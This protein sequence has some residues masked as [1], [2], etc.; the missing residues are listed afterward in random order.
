M[1]RRIIVLAM[2]AVLAVGLAGIRPSLATASS[3]TFTLSIPSAYL[4]A[5]PDLAARHS[6]SI[7]KGESYTVTG[8]NEIGDW[9]LLDYAG[10]AGD[11]SWMKV[12]FGVVTGDLGSVPVVFGSFVAPPPPPPPAPTEAP[13]VTGGGTSTG[14]TDTNPNTGNTGNTGNNSGADNNPDGGGNDAGPIPDGVHLGVTIVST[15]VYGRSGPS[16]KSTKLLSFFKGEAYTADGRNA[17]STWVHLDINVWVPAYT[18]QVKGSL[19]S[20]SVAGSGG[21]STSSGSAGGGSPAPTAPA[22]VPTSEPPNT[23]FEPVPLPGWSIP[24]VSSAARD[25]YQ[26]GLA[27]GNNPNS[28]SK[29]GDCNSTT[30]FFLAMFD[31][32]EYALG[33]YA[34]LQG[35]IDNFA[36]SFDRNGAAAHDGLN[37]ASIFDPTWAD[38]QQC[39]RGE[40][41]VECELRIHNPSIAFV[42]VGTNGGWQTNAEYEGNLRKLLDLLI[43]RGV[44]PIMST[45]ADNLEGNGRFNQ[46]VVRLA[47]EYQLPLWDFASAAWGLPGGGLADAYHLSWGRAYYDGDTAPQRGWQVR[48]L[49]ALQSLDAVWRAA[50]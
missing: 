35:A 33:G 8:R 42:S 2:V 45:K 23:N 17:E 19:A 16:L 39:E 44:L 26:R 7:F 11:Q 15:S 32:G 22:P 50:R 6:G 49:T 31:K 29:I 27:L 10:V 46:I 21:G 18:V 5:E 14:T 28:F 3:V 47:N 1:A 43:A 38:P 24:T 13:V 4:R 34:N 9:V 20:L 40:T 37:T 12:S 30:P 36:G 41:P 25:I 48:N